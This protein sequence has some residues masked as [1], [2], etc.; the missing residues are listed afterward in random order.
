[1]NSREQILSAIKKK[2][3]EDSGK[4]VIPIFPTSSGVVDKFIEVLTGIGGSAFN[5][6]NYGQV[7]EIILKNFNDCKWVLSLSENLSIGEKY[8]VV[9]DP[10]AFEKLDLLI[11]ESGL[12]VAENGSVWVTENEIKERVLPFITQHLVVIIKKGNIVSNMQEAYDKIGEKEYDF[13]TFIAGPSK[14][15]D[16]EQSLVLG[17]H[18]PKTMTVFLME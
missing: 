16:I 15:A 3:P 13:A 11:L 14:T 4:L 2:Q 6:E 10:H 9:S 17:A 12:G 18:G 1:M 8:P 7:L 5:A